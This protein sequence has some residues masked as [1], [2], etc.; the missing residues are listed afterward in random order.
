MRKTRHFL[1]TAVLAF[2]AIACLHVPFAAAFVQ[3]SFER[4][5]Q[6]TGPVNLEVNT[7]SG[8]IDIHTGSSNQVQIIGRIKASE[9]FGGGSAQERVRRLEANPPILQSGN[10]LRIGHIDDPELRR[11]ISISYELVVPPNTRLQSRTGSGNQTVSGLQGQVEVGTGSGSLTISDIG[12]VVRAETGSGN[13]EIDRAKGS[14]RAKTGS[15]SIQ[16]S[17]IAGGFEGDTGSGNIKV[18]QT[19]PGA[20]RVNT[21]SGSI[22]LRGV[23]GSLDAQTGS[24]S[25]LAE[26]DPTGMWKLRTGSGGVRLRMASGASFDL[27]AHTSS[28]TISLDQPITVQGTIGRKEV[29]GK[30]HGGGVSVNVETGSGNIEIQ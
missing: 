27:D 25:L 7:G 23:H 5:L 9:W 2:S 26:G 4:T 11:N 19:A 29:H 16:A 21:G 1:P 8:N 10:D 18:E 3:G 24:G 6:V 15:G 13:I 17:G 30:V 14:V 28:G 12:D 20:V 22:E